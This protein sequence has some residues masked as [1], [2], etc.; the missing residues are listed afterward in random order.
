MVFLFLK[1]LNFLMMFL[2]VENGSEKFVY[3]FQSCGGMERKF[4]FL[5]W[6]FMGFGFSMR[7]FFLV[8]FSLIIVCF[9]GRRVN[10][11]LFLQF[12]VF[13]N[14]DFLI[15]L[16]FFE[17]MIIGMGVFFLFFLLY[18][19][20]NFVFRSFFCIFS[21]VGKKIWFFRSLIFILIIV[22]F[23]C[24]FVFIIKFY[25]FYF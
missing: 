6:Y 20:L 18:G 19:I 8:M 1:V 21:D 16:C 11:L 3:V 2:Y 15:F 22:L 14:F 25:N 12:F 23:F 7:K 10:F 5:R 13:S 24:C 17:F 9:F 4:F